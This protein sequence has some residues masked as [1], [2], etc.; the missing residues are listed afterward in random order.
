MTVPNNVNSQV[1]VE[2][3]NVNTPPP[4]HQE[5]TLV[6]DPISKP[7]AFIKDVGNGIGKGFKSFGKKLKKAFKRK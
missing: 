4:T 1:D 7:V 6:I 3:G 5:V 2:A